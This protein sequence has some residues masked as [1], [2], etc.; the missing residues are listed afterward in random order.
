MEKSSNLN[1]EQKITSRK[2]LIT[3]FFVDALDVI[4][5]FSIA[6]LSGSVVMVT[7]VLEGVSDLVSSG[8]LLIGFNRSLH[9]EDETHPFGYGTEIYFW[10][11]LAAIIMFGLTSTISFYFGWQR[12][13][14][15]EP[16]KAINFAIAILILTF[17]T[18]GYAFFL[19]FRRLLKKRPPKHILRI[20][21]HSSLVETKTTFILD[22]M[23]ATASLMGA[24]ALGIY[25]LT[26]DIRFDGL[27]AMLIGIVLAVFSLFLVAGIRDLVIGKRASK[28]TEAKISE[29]ALGIKGVEQVLGIKTLHLG[30]EKLLVDLDVH[31][32]SRLGTRELEKIIDKIK[33]RIREKVPSAKYIQVELETPRKKISA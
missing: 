23:G 26:G 19:S 3:S 11:F 22:L 8:L 2:V 24:I 31:M 6:I 18:N 7:Q 29:A 21:Y 27:G 28:E 10:S 9:K 30:T 32:Q 16:I 5:S 17:F 15:P 25:V 4:L 13:F 14:H 12:F 1:T 33:E 20:F